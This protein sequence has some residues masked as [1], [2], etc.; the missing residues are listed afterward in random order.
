MQQSPAHRP[1]AFKSAAQG[2]VSALAKARDGAELD[3]VFV[4]GSSAWGT[5]AP[6]T[7]ASS[8]RA[9]STPPNTFSVA[10]HRVG[11]SDTRIKTTQSMTQS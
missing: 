11:P 5:R 3:K 6:A 4:A 8:V 1:D 10:L 9:A 2:I 7:C